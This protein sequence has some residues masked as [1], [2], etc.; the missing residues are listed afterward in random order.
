MK[1]KPNLQIF[2]LRSVAG[3]SEEQVCFKHKSQINVL[4]STNS[5]PLYKKEVT[6][7]QFFFQI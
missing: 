7:I 3:Q 5:R 2:L 4:F 1:D 6:E